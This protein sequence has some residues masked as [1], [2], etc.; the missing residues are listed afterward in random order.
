MAPLPSHHSASTTGR[1]TVSPTLSW[2]APGPKGTG[3]LETPASMGHPSFLFPTPAPLSL[4]EPRGY[5]ARL[6]PQLP[7]PHGECCRP[8]GHCWDR[9]CYSR[10]LWRANPLVPTKLASLGISIPGTLSPAFHSLAVRQPPGKRWHSSLAPAVLSGLPWL[11]QPQ[12][13]QALAWRVAGA[14]FG[15]KGFPS[16]DSAASVVLKTILARV[17]LPRL[18]ATQ[19]W[20]GVFVLCVHVCV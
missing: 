3:W 4:P 1:L 18:P 14:N 2:M 8:D 13:E 20:A 11:P 5:T 16:A 9:S 7:W 10:V 17:F 12:Q 6:H 19:S 15:P